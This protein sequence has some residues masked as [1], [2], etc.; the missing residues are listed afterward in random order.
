MG[1]LPGTGTKAQLSTPQRDRPQKRAQGTKGLRMR[2]MIQ[3][4]GEP[5]RAPVSGAGGEVAAWSGEPEDISAACLK[6]KVIGKFR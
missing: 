4:N 3:A 2:Q 1:T 6:Q 5:H